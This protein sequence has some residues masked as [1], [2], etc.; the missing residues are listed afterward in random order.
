DTVR[1]EAGN[2]AEIY[3]DF[4]NFL[5]PFV[6]HCHNL[7]HED[8]AMMIRFDIVEQSLE[9]EPNASEAAFGAPNEERTAPPPDL[10]TNT[11]GPDPD[12]D[13]VARAQS[14]TVQPRP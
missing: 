1:L 2:E 7:E 14:N 3:I 8:M 11:I 13:D 6:M 10:G 5:G 9:G 12:I 4:Q